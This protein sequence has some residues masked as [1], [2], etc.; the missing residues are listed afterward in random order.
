MI[1]QA[2]ND[3]YERKIAEEHSSVAP[4]GFE[5]KELPFIIEL[6]R[7]FHELHEFSLIY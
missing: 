7:I 3:Y 6:T 1:L 4:F 5:T 2:L